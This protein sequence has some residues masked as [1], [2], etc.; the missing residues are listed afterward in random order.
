MFSYGVRGQ[1]A[2]EFLMTYGWAFIVMIGVIAGIVALDPLGMATSSTTSSCG[3]SDLIVCDD[4]RVI[5]LEDG[6]IA[7]T[8]TNRRGEQVSF[9]EFNITS[10]DG[11]EVSGFDCDTPVNLTRG[12]SS[13]IVC[14]DTLEESTF[15][16]GEP[17]SFSYEARAYPSSL[18]DRYVDVMSGEVRAGSVDSSRTTSDIKELLAG[19]TEE[20]SGEAEDYDSA[21]EDTFEILSNMEGDG[22]SSNPYII[23]DSHE[24]QAMNEDLSAH[25]MLSNNI[26]AAGTSTW[27]GGEGFQPLGTSSEFTGSLDG[28]GYSINGLYINTGDERVGL[29]SETNGGATISNL[30]LT[31]IDISGERSVGGLI[32]VS[33]NSIVQDITVNGQ[34]SANDDNTGL[35]IGYSFN[36]IQDITTSGTVEGDDFT[37]GVVG[38]HIGDATNIESTATVTGSQSVGG[39][40]GYVY[41]TANTVH[42]ENVAF[43]GSVTASVNWAGGVSGAHF[44]GSITNAEVEGTIISNQGGGG[45]SAIFQGATV[46]NVKNYAD[47]SGQEFNAGI[48]G[49]L[50]GGSTLSNAYSAG[51]V[52]GS[53]TVAGLVG[54][55]DGSIETSY[56]IGEVSAS[57]SYVGGLVGRNEGSVSN[58]YWD[59]QSSEQSDSDGGTGLETSQMQGSDA[60]NNMDALDFDTVWTTTSSYPTLQS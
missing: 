27:N 10:V 53:N 33:E 41:D 2:V 31:N 30:A 16:G 48:F 15:V 39:I 28:A 25:Y 11:Q 24:L 34:V 7:L 50:N 54:R 36:D 37:G 5:A 20:T 59:T 4:E 45:I 44:G 51:S 18:G 6:G 52:Q 8:F 1:A 58:S 60:E 56:S 26:L 22:S 49:Q 3:D 29:F 38:V 21:P 46:E 12:R 55:N 32:G 57:G 47:I 9:E 40:F 35:L 43:D 13:T 23:T 17:A 14:N 19:G 42:I